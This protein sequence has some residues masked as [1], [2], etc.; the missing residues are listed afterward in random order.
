MRNQKEKE[1]RLLTFRILGFRFRDYHMRNY[2]N[3]GRRE[4]QNEMLLQAN[5]LSRPTLLPCACS[6]TQA[7][8]W[9]A[10]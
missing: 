4:S 9:L 3:K 10:G 5:K 1:K 8:P 7:N 6:Q 2:E